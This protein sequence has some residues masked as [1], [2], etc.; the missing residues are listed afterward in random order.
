MIIKKSNKNKSGYTVTLSK[1]DWL[2]IG[3]KAG[4]VKESR[5]REEQQQIDD[6]YRNFQQKRK[7]SKMMFQNQESDYWKNTQ[8][9]QIPIEKDLPKHIEFGTSPKL[10]LKKLKDSDPIGNE[11]LRENTRQ[12][13]EPKLPKNKKPVLDTEP[14]PNR[15]RGHAGRNP[16][17]LR[18]KKDN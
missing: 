7:P 13:W 16:D 4:W 3:K 2:N 18:M 1:K 11:N 15:F 14:T 17:L 8:D 10:D 5:S 9:R 12:N 6:Q